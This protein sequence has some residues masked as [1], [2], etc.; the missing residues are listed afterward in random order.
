MF[1]ARIGLRYN[2]TDSLGLDVAV[3]HY[4]S[5]IKS[6][7]IMNGANM[8]LTP[9][10]YSYRYNSTQII[11][12]LPYG[13]N[14][15]QGFEVRP[16]VGAGAAFITGKYNLTNIA[17]NNPSIYEEA[18]YPVIGSKVDAKSSYLIAETGKLEGKQS[19]T[20]FVYSGGISLNY[21][22]D[23]NFFVGI[24]YLIGNNPGVTYKDV[25][26][27]L[28]VSQYMGTGEGEAK[29]TF[30]MKQKGGIAQAALITVGYTF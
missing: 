30:K 2:A 7:S 9:I 23:S 16:Y 15:S 18:N 3:G 20:A 10:P 24:K 28:K 27:N 26:V 11:G 14:L 4:G 5:N 19:T 1:N 29:G 17:L 8:P 21:Y 6:E 22:T 25:S 12:S 13:I